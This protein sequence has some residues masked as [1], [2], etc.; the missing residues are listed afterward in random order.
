MYEV[1]MPKMGETME[2]GTIEKWRKKEGDKVEKGEILYDLATDKVSL[3][4]E[5]F[6]SGY[7][8][9][10]VKGEGQEVPIMEVIAYIGQKDEPIPAAGQ[11]PKPEPAEEQTKVEEKPADVN[12]NVV[13]MQPAKPASEK[14]SISPIAR[15]LAEANNIDISTVK[16]TG[17]AGRI[18][19]EDIEALISSKGKNARIFISP[20]ARKTASDLGIDY[21]IENIVGSGPSGRIVN[22]DILAFSKASETVEK[23]KSSVGGAN[24]EIK[25]LSA[26]PVKGVRKVIADKMVQSKQNI[27]HI[28]LDSVCDVTSLISLR[29][30]LKD[31]PEKNY[32]IK[33]TYTD[34]IIKIA[35][36]ALSEFRA[37]NSSFQ[38]DSHIIY[39]D[40][41]IGVAVAANNSLIVPTI[42][43][44]DMLGILEIAKKRSELVEKGRSGKLALEEITN[45]TFTISNLGMYGVRSFTAIINPPQGAI[46]TVS[47]MYESPVAVNGKVEIRTLMGV[48][49]AVDH[50][51][52]DGALAAQFLSRVK[53]L[54]ENPEMLIL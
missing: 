42:Y 27:P 10:I 25:I 54:I 22:S 44:A 45:A 53:E 33:I 12:N 46:M 20:F 39:E 3:E 13:Q 24:R 23:Q 41:N 26:T 18:V 35:S 50:R 8:R 28:I 47:E 52:I 38:N 37:V 6:N 51:I 15:N 9:K 17:P 21:K 2:K 36:V 7:L 31:K 32:G 14:I 34:F 49:V 5:S 1:L 4:V 29:A 11:T 30:R 16:G 19:K 43:N 40:I 48:G